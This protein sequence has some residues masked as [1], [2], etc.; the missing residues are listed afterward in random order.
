[1]KRIVF[2]SSIVRQVRQVRPQYRSSHNLASDAQR[3]TQVRTDGRPFARQYEENMG[4]IIIASE[5][6]AAEQQ[7]KEKR[8]AEQQAKAQ[9]EKEEREKARRQDLLRKIAKAK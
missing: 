9:R 4:K 6:Q 1:M 2:D 7:E 8:A 3:F 5:I